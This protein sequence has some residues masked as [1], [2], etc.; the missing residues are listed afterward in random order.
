MEPLKP[1]LRTPRYMSPSSLKKFYSDRTKYFKDY[2]APMRPPRTPQT[3]AMSGGSAFDAYVKC[4]LWKDLFGAEPPQEFQVEHLLESQVEPHVR[5]FA[6]EAGKHVMDAYVFAGAYDDLLKDLSKSPVDPKFEFDAQGQVSLNGEIDENTVNLF[7]KPDIWYKTP[8]GVDVIRDWKVN[9]Y[10]AKAGHSPKKGYTI[11][12]DGW[13]HDV[14]KKS[15]SH[16]KVHK[17]YEALDLAGVEINGAFSFEEVEAGWA[18]QTCIY[19]WLQGIKVGDPLIIGIEQL[20]CKN[21]LKDGLPV[22]IRVAKHMGTCSKEF[23]VDLITKAQVAWDQ[24]RSG[25]IFDWMDRDES[26]KKC[27]MLALACET[28]SNM[29]VQDAIF[30]NTLNDRPW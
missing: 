4:A 3:N 20:V 5:D 13:D 7:G 11:I 24:I 22:Q 23:Q 26:D 10:C 8:G 14:E 19:S 16:G 2:L 25:H 12:R 15:A 1:E 28:M 21:R 27:V 9:G 18:A 6:F 17:M 29:P 30:Y